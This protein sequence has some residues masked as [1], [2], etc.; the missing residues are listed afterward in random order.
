MIL[1][2]PRVMERH[3]DVTEEDVAMAWSHAIAMR[4]RSFDPPVHI[5]AAGVDTKGRL[6]EMIGV[7]L[8]DGGDSRLPRHEADGQDGARA[9]AR[10]G[11]RRSHG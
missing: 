2:H 1:T 11:V 9:R 4:H 7:E 5:A 6:I 8:E 10:L 3:P